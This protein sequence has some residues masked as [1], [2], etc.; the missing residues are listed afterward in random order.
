MIFEDWGLASP[1]SLPPSLPL[2]SRV[3]VLG[4]G[5]HLLHLNFP[6]CLPLFARSLESPSSPALLWERALQPQGREES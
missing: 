4:K 6:H 2:Q 3:V 1:L 5:R